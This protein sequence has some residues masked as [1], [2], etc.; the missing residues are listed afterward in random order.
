MVN[1][2]FADNYIHIYIYN[3]QKLHVWK[4]NDISFTKLKK[5][6]P[7][8]WQISLMYMQGISCSC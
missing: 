5:D 3:C 7:E 2:K 1:E 4:S 6:L 8:I